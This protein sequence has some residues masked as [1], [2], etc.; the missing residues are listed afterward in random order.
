MTPGTHHKTIVA[1]S[2]GDCVHVAG[3]TRFLAVAEDVGYDTYFT[4]PATGLEAF[5]DAVVAHDPDVIGIS[6]RLTPENARIMLSDLR[7][8]LAAAGVLG[9]KRIFF[10]G[11]PPVAA[12][13][14]EF[15]YIDVVFSGQEPSH[16]IRQALEGNIAAEP[17]PDDF[18]QH[19]I[20]RIQWKAPL[21]ILRHHFGIPARTI[22]PTVDGISVIAEAGVL[23]VISLGPDQDAQENFFRP[24]LQ[25][26]R[27]IGAGGVPFRTEDDLR[28][29]YAASRRGNYPLLRSYSGTA[30]HLRYADMLVRTINNAWCATS[31]FWF[32][33]MDG[34]GPSPLEQSIREHQNLMRWHGE[35]DIP[36]EGNE[37]HH[38]GMRDAPDV[39]VCASAYLYAHNARH[40]GVH[41]YLVQYMF[42]SP[43]QLSNAM[44]LA[45]ALAVFEIIDS[46][47]GDTFRAWRQ[48]RTGLLSYPVDPDRARA[49]LAQSTM[50]QMAVQ[51]HIVHIVGYTEADHAATANE[52]IE[53]AIMT[54]EV[55]ETALRGNPDMTTDPAVQR[56]KHDLIA[57]THHLIEAIRALGPDVP[58]P[59]VSPRVLAQAVALGLLDAPQLI[60][61]AYAPGRVR[62][63]SIGGAMQAVDAQGQPLGEVARI[64]AVLALEEQAT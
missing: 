12:V 3:V 38:W 43:P 13:A 45:R 54:Q 21:P 7:G 24:A 59:L 28:A 23:D 51:P 18:P 34:R 2:L 14:R 48:V 39:V 49:H 27:S 32:N 44:D 40:F 25:D 15:D 20:E 55:I 35:R 64:A 26:R 62:T 1:G 10:G 30:D 46:F 53:S 37:L 31:L 42:Q 47:T 6:Y 60:N 36:V 11:T 5:V 4:G 33:A 61:N 16:T 52:V 17:T 41:D 50:L 9:Q 8:M 19:V 57:E 22:M 63:R 58:D 29:L 56:R